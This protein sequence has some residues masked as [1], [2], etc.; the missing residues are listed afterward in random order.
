MNVCGK[1]ARTNPPT[2]LNCF[3]CG[4]ELEISAEQAEFL[5]LSLRKLESWEKGIN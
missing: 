4:A 1:C 5:N 3:Y 2:R